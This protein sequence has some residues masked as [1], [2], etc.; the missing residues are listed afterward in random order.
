MATRQLREAARH[1]GIDIIDHVVV[2]SPES[3]L[4]GVGHYPFREAGVL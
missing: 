3:D 2:G 1:I 4:K